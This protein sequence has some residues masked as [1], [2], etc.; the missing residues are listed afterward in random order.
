MTARVFVIHEVAAVRA[1]IPGGVT[2][3]PEWI[4]R[5]ALMWAG[6]G[7][8]YAQKKYRTPSHRKGVRPN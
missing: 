1:V 8:H 7:Q 4:L 3:K 5:L 6:T 2:D